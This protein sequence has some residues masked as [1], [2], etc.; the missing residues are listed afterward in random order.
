V[1]ADLDALAESST[2]APLPPHA[3]VRPRRTG[4]WGGSRDHTRAGE[5]PRS[6]PYPPRVCVRLVASSLQVEVGRSSS[7][8]AR[9]PGVTVGST[10]C[11]G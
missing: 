2:D 11:A 5:P 6:A 8:A 4:R 3:R 1:S 7:V 10:Y 9:A